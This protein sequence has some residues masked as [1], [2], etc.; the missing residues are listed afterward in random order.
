MRENALAGLRQSE[1]PAVATIEEQQ[2][3]ARPREFV[4]ALCDLLFAAASGELETVRQ[5]L[6]VGGVDINSVDYEGRSVLMIAATAGRLK[7]V[8]HLIENGAALNLR[9]TFGKTAL[10]NALEKNHRAVADALHKAGATLG[11]DASTSSAKL[12]DDTRRGDFSTVRSLLEYGADVNAADY[13]QRTCLH[14]AASEGNLPIVRYLITEGKASINVADRWGGTPLADAI[15][16]AHAEVSKCLIEHGAKLEWDEVRASGELCELARSGDG[17]RVRMLLEAGCAVDS[18]DC[19]PP[20]RAPSSPPRAH[21]RRHARTQSPPPRTHSRR[22]RARS[23]L[24]PPRPDPPGHRPDRA[25]TNLPPIAAAACASA[26]LGARISAPSRLTRR[27]SVLLRAVACHPLHRRPPHVPAPGG[28]RGR[29]VGGGEP[30]GARLL[31][32][33]QGPLG[34]DAAARRGAGRA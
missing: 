34:R 5:A 12:C 29:A 28:E 25:R 9:D 30:L 13:D 2:L 16:H 18:A 31:R 10:A 20:P 1:H 32:Q 26:S 4:V 24:A 8:E 21:S 6:T 22:R 19:T 17:Y 33:L 14:L 27:E 23:R 3:A 11:W 7:V 15:R